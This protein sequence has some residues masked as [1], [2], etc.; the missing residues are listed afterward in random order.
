MRIPSEIYQKNV[1]H[2]VLNTFLWKLP[3]SVNKYSNT[4]Y[5]TI[6]MKPKDEKPDTYIEHIHESKN[7]KRNGKRFNNRL[8]L[9][10][11]IMSI[12]LK[13]LRLIPNKLK[14]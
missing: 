13:H 1:F 6:K 4:H 5:N 10:F 7:N 8:Y 11:F 12:F 14:R 2:P 9:L 3:D